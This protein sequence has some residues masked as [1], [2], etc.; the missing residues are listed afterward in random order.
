MEKRVFSTLFVNKEG[1]KYLIVGLGNIGDEYAHTRHNIGFDMIDAFADSVHAAWEDKRYGFVAK[2]RVKNAEP[3][4]LKPSTYMNLSGNAIRYWLQQEKIAVENMLVLV[5]DLNLPFGSI[6]IRKQG[7]NGGHNGLG[8][9][10]SVLGTENYS[11]VRFGIGNQ[12]TRG[13]QCNFVLGRWTEE[14]QAALPERLKVV[15]EII[16]CFCLQGIDRT[17][18]LYN[19]K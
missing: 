16:P 6:R 18:N 12:F 1:M 13:A 7:S 5:D 2:C 3:V 15:A 8:N 14:E 19:G 9:I 4:L 11:R 10:Q 17:M